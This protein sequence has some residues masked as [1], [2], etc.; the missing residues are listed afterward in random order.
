MDLVGF[1]LHFSLGPL[2]EL[3]KLYR[4]LLTPE[5][6]FL[7]L[8]FQPQ[9]MATTTQSKILPTI[10]SKSK[11]EGK[12]GPLSGG[13]AAFPWQHPK[14]GSAWMWHLSPSH[15]GAPA[16]LRAPPLLVVVQLKESPAFTPCINCK[17]MEYKY[18][19]R[20]KLWYKLNQ[21]AQGCSAHTNLWY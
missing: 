9:F 19:S 15:K 13:F 18:A 7:T 12:H 17:T 14:A 16:G 8:L 6:I 11:Y 21:S 2:C 1:C 20:D 10:K 3:S 4:F 5:L